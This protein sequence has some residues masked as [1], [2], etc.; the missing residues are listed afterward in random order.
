MA[1]S[2]RKLVWQIFPSFLIIIAVSLAIVTGY[3]TT[4]FKDFYLTNTEQDLTIRA[5]LVRQKMSGLGTAFAHSENTDQ[6]CKDIGEQTGTRVTV[7]LPDGEVVGDSFGD[8]TKMENHRDRPEIADALKWEKGVSIRYSQTLEQNMMYIALPI[9]DDGRVAVVVRTA[10]SVS[11][12]DNEIQAIKA[13]VFWAFA[14]MVLV[15]AFVSLF[16]SRRIARPIEE[17]KDGALRFANG[18]LETRLAVPQALELSDLATTMNTMAERLDEKITAFKN[19]SNELEAVHSSM[20]EGVIAIDN[21][22]KIIT[23]NEAAAKVFG[24][25][26]KA[27]YNRFVL[28]VARNIAFQDFIR[29]AL[30][31]NDPV[32]ADITI[33]QDKEV[34][35]N[36]HSTALYNSGDHRMGTLIIFHDITRLRRLETMH[37]DFAANVSHELKTPMT[38]I[39]GFVET[40]QPMIVNKETQDALHFLSIIKNNVNRLIYLVDDLLALS[41][42]ERLEGTQIEFENQN[43]CI[44]INGAVQSCETSARQKEIGIEVNCS[45]DMTAMVDPILI[46]QALTNLVDNAVKYSGAGSR[47]SIEAFSTDSSNVIKVRDSGQGIAEPHLPKIFNRFYRVDKGRSRSE[48]GTGLGLAIVKHIVQYHHGSVSVESKLGRGSCFEIKLPREAV[49]L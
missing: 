22:E 45:E 49:S 41:R 39:K 2:K 1:P 6:F 48:G 20:K 9:I 47:V 37:K 32:E 15:A 43:L 3:S 11:S 34:I 25:P 16:V 21:D 28:E 29:S 19:R 38:S 40:L 4:Y 35:L 5:K 23:V 26:A 36:I 12:I 27:L 30:E 7:I 14:L 33:V 24:F 8:I 46:E 17:M 44:L 13:R 18:E 42:L 31:T 10:L